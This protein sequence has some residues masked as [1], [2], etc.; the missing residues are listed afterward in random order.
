MFYHNL[1]RADARWGGSE[2][3]TV[4][5][6]CWAT[7]P[8]PSTGAGESARTEIAKD[9]FALLKTGDPNGKYWMPAMSDAPPAQ[10]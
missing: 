6:P 10:S 1:E 2:S 4:P 8:Y 5:Y 3:G 9:Q 7:F